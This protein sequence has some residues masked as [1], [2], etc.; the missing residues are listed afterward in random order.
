MSFKTQL[1]DKQRMFGHKQI[2]LQKPKD[3]GLETTY[4]NDFTSNNELKRETPTPKAPSPDSIAGIQLNNDKLNELRLS[5]RINYIQDCWNKTRCIKDVY[6]SHNS[7]PIQNLNIE[8]PPR[9]ANTTGRRKCILSPSEIAK[10]VP[11]MPY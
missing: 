9:T 4:R 1:T 5:S 8:K 10:N 6:R 7:T 11:Y 2:F 3:Y